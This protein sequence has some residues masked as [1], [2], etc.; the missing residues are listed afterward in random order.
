ML[1]ELMIKVNA[2]QKWPEK[3]LG[4]KRA[5]I[6]KLGVNHTCYCNKFLAIGTLVITPS[7]NG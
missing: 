3:I 5:R 2:L 7:S 1:I 6:H 4:L